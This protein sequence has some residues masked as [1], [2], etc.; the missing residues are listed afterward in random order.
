MTFQDLDLDLEPRTSVILCPQSH[1]VLMLS[2][3]RLRGPGGSGDENA[4]TREVKRRDPGNEV[5]VWRGLLPTL[6]LPSYK[7]EVYHPSYYRLF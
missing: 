7:S 6:R 5:V 2:L 1:L 4:R 3:Q